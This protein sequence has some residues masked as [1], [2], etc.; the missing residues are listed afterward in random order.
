M[1]NCYLSQLSSVCDT[2]LCTSVLSNLLL[3]AQLPEVKN[4][5]YGDFESKYDRTV[6]KKI[7]GKAPEVIF[8]TQSGKELERLNIEKFDR[9]D[10]FVFAFSEEFSSCMHTSMRPLDPYCHKSSLL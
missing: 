6:F 4:F 3:V 8:Y 1:P 2:L 9:Y 7:P 5:I 10:A